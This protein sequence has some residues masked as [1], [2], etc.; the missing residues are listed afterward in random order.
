MDREQIGA[1]VGTVLWAGATYWLAYSAFWRPG[2][3]DFERGGCAGAA[4]VFGLLL[5][6]WLLGIAG[7]FVMRR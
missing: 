6:L 2:L 5:L 7:S 4:L 1:I 3:T